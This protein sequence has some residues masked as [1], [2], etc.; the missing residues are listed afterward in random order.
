MAEA[1]KCDRCNRFYELSEEDQK[2][3]DYSY[4]M[5][6]PYVKI[7]LFD[8]Y[9]EREDSTRWYDLCPKCVELL[10]K[11]LENP[12]SSSDYGCP[13]NKCVDCRHFTSEPNPFN[14]N[15]HKGVYICNL[16]KVYISGNCSRPD[17]SDMTP[18][19]FCKLG[20]NFVKENTEEP[21]YKDPC[22]L[23]NLSDPC[24]QCDYGYISEEE[25]KKRW[26]ERNKDKV[27]L[28]DP[29]EDGGL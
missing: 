17:I 29:Y 2:N 14:S 25:K 3:R 15:D 27:K 1:R 5:K 11:W 21:E 18:K 7:M 6:G 26:A 4:Y 24:E 8:R 12:K 28:S 22:K 19:D 9:G 20:C 23:C 16:K 13:C 10:N